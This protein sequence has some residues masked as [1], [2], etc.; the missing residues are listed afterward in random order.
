LKRKVNDAESVGNIEFKIEKAHE[1]KEELDHEIEKL[2][3]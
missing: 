3:E 1:R 2:K